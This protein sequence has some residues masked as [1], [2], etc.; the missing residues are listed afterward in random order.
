M[1]HACARS[2][3]GS[4]V[5]LV[6]PG[7][8]AL[9]R[10][11]LPEGFPGKR[12]QA[13]DRLL[14]R[15]RVRPAAADSFAATLGGFFGIDAALPVA[16]LTWLADTGE[17]ASGYLLRADPV[18]LR[19]DRS[20]LRLFDSDTLS[21]D[22]DEADALVA[23][24]NAHFSDRGWQLHAPHPQRWYLALSAIPS[25]TTCPPSELSGQDI[26]Q[27]LPAGADAGEWHAV[28]NEV[29]MLLHSHA[30]NSAREQRGAPLV[31]SLWF[32]GGGVSPAAL[33]T[34]VRRVVTDDPLAMGLAG[35]A[36]V[37]R[38]DV[39][40]NA[41]ELLA[42]AVDGLTLVAHDTLQLL[43]AH[44]EIERWRATLMQLE[45]DWFAPLLEALRNGRLSGLELF[46]VNGRRYATN[47]SRQRHF[48]KLIRPYE[49]RCR[50][51]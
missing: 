3:P 47:R 44:G 16:P 51:K 1:I 4:H 48:W 49:E 41:G 19:A 45:T 7:L 42:P 35:M 5:A 29:Q 18:Y 15:S 10:K 43:A 50:Y 11:D 24:I 34:P 2:K 36:N 8:C 28:L 30:V 40:A 33:Q 46:P 26:N 27:G 6:I 22:Q 23:A 12:P 21:I 38:R 13:L 20:C 14:S 37:E 31:N 17:K 39:P 25:I 9:D 32:W